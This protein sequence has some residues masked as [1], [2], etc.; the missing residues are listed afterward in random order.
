[1]D[2]KMT[3][4]SQPINS[5]S[6]AFKY[7][8]DGLHTFHNC[9]FIKHPRFQQAYK[10]GLI[11]ARSGI[12]IEW[13]VHVAIWAASQCA[14]LQGDFIECGVHT[15]ILSGAVMTWLDFERMSNKKYYLLDTFEGIPLEQISTTEFSMGVA[16]MNKKYDF[17]DK[18]Y[19]GVKEKFKKWKNCNVIRGKVPDTLTQVKSEKFSYVSIDMN[20]TAAEIAA[21]EFLWP[22]MVP[23]AIMLLDDYGWESH[24]QQKIAFDE[25]ALKYGIQILSL[26]TGQAILMKPYTIQ[27]GNNE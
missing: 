26:P 16:Q 12:S 27:H 13:R 19:L 8:S 2:Q 1:M 4:S 20:V 14:P 11:N 25:F 24:I 10:Y 7:S 21:A 5:M 18:T 3:K 23:G 9:D 15:G 6:R 22:K 17:G